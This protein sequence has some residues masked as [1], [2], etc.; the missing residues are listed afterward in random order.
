MP[1]RG[2]LDGSV[3]YQP[4]AMLVLSFGT[5]GALQA[6]LRCSFMFRY[7]APYYLHMATGALKL[8]VRMF[9]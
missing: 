6:V 3:S 4:A 2:E 7:K 8:V 5:V 9:Y 1:Y